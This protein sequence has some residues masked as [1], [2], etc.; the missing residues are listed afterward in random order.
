MTLNDKEAVLSTDN[1]RQNAT[2][3]N[4]LLPVFLWSESQS[5]FVVCVS[6]CEVV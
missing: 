4:Q 5:Q 3:I 6:A 1:N 2:S